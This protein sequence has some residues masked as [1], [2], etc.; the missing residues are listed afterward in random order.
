[1]DEGEVRA[2]PSAVRAAA[3]V[4]EKVQC[5]IH[6]KEACLATGVTHVRTRP[7]S[8][9]LPLNVTLQDGSKLGE[10]L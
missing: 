4:N 7:R 8:G 2:R 1:M 5:G 6:F 10:I 9:G 3:A